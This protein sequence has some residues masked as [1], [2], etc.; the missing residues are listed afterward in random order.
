M[1]PEIIS[2][3]NG[4]NPYDE[5][6]DLWSLGIT[7][8]ELAEKE[9]P[10]SEVHPMRALM[11]IPIRDAPTLQNTKKWSREFVD[12]VKECLTKDHKK[13][14]NADEMLHHAFVANIGEDKRCLVQLLEEAKRAKMKV[15]AE[16]ESSMED[17]KEKGAGVTA[18]E[19]D[20]DELIPAPI[21]SSSAGGIP[22]LI[23]ENGA[24]ADVKPRA[25]S[26]AQE[27]PVERPNGV[28][29]SASVSVPNGQSLHG[30]TP[31]PT[32][33]GSDA[34]GAAKNRQTSNSSAPLPTRRAPTVRATLKQP[35]VTRREM[36]IKQAKIMNKALMMQQLKELAAQ[37]AIHMK[38]LEKLRKTHKREAE[39]LETEYKTSVSR[40][41][42]T[43]ASR[44]KTMA[45]R[46]TSEQERLAKRHRSD[47]TEQQ[48]NAQREEKKTS[49][50]LESR[51]KS[52]LNDFKESQRTS[53]KEAEK[54]H[55]EAKKAKKAEFKSLGKKEKTQAEAD[56]KSEGAAWKLNLEQLE[57]QG[58]RKTSYLQARER[59][60]TMAD[61]SA[62][63]MKDAHTKFLEQLW[64]MVDLKEKQLQERH[65]SA[66]TF[67]TESH[68]LEQAFM[69]RRIALQVSQLEKE[70]ALIK[71][72]L[73]K[74]QSVEK[75]Q[76]S[77]LLKSDQ[78]A[79]LKEWTKQ[80]AQRH[81]DFLKTSKETMKAKMTMKREERAA[82]QTQL[83]EEF[84][85][86]QKAL[87]A[88]FNAKQLK[89]MTDEETLLSQHHASQLE[90]LSVDQKAE[91]ETMTV[92]HAKASANLDERIR[93]T[94][95]LHA[96]NFWEER[97]ALLKERQKLVME[98]RKTQHTEQKQLHVSQTKEL[99]EL[100]AAQLAELLQ[101]MQTQQRSEPEIQK[102]QADFAAEKAEMESKQHA[103]EQALLD[104]IRKNVTSIKADHKIARKQLASVAPPRS[105]GSSPNGAANNADSSDSEPNGKRKSTSVAHE[106][107]S[108]DLYDTDSTDGDAIPIAVIPH[109]STSEETDF[110]HS[111]SAPHTPGSSKRK[112]NVL[113]N[114]DTGKYLAAASASSKHSSEERNSRRISSKPGT[115]LPP[116]LTATLPPPLDSSDSPGPVRK[117]S[118]ASLPLPG[119]PGSS[120]KRKHTRHTS[121]Q[122]SFVPPEH[123]SPASSP[124]LSASN[125][126]KKK[127][128]RTK[129]DIS[130]PVRASPSP[131]SPDSDSD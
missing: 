82:L 93:V 52:Q 69:K 10:L 9:P 30:S 118:D 101:L 4:K 77:K 125:H 127:K 57:E 29:R 5:R 78:R 92:E 126:K 68:E 129:T 43:T 81:K 89:E 121:I 47:M 7:C 42:E 14:H 20:P 56:L 26:D 13:R 16:E 84:N 40:L 1:A 88:E 75:A 15:V 120:T 28:E 95:A 61:A 123:S 96:R 91:L 98:L 17:P 32:L 19:D 59:F 48:Q 111:S 99:H 122:T 23:S 76:Q 117:N 105:E 109:G 87:D 70:H 66:K 110:Q 71:Q 116:T 107:V 113:D 8:I 55:K 102:M 115:P 49:R 54:D 24:G 86:K 97:W 103:A 36:E 33:G 94:N 53:R 41:K 6:I 51:Q 128:T 35:S 119:T 67:D 114:D 21:A 3:K 73:E 39:S 46:H 44:D 45:D 131:P 83:Q 79:E 106:G 74:E 64:E 50:D 11:Q 108:D 37:R 34:N 60:S 22:S 2:N 90:S 100:H 62:G 124:D 130:T 72:Q 85:S 12:F 65:D 18:E 31:S 25:T 80:K 63:S 38:E 27:R 58:L 104:A 112:S